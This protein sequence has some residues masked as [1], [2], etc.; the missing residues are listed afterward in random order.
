MNKRIFWVKSFLSFKKFLLLFLAS[1]ILIIIN[2]ASTNSKAFL[3]NYK[4]KVNII[5]EFY[6]KYSRIFFGARGYEINSYSNNITYS[7]KPNKLLLCT[8][9]KNENLYA[10]E[11]IEYYYHLGFNKIIIFDNNEI[12]GEKFDDILKDYI[13]K[14]IVDIEDIRGLKSIQMAAINYCYRKNMYLYDWIAFFDFDEY[15]FLNNYSNIKHYL[16]NKEFEKCQ[17]I[18]FNWYIYDDNNLLKYDNRRIVERFTH[19]KKI[20]SLTKFIARG[21]L[22]KLLISSAHIAININYCNSKGELV[23]PKS[24]LEL[25]KE[26][27][28]KAYIKHYY[29]KTA[30]EYCFKV[31]RG[32]VQFKYIN[33]NKNQII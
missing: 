18:L 10:K 19:L 9:G 23:Y 29:T 16:F 30:E 11:F 7:K 22:N 3:F 32:D 20:T 28:S 25:P 8:I 2:I 15:L 27:N 33:P 5:N 17:S 6:A 24:Y 21:N 26:N 13:S 31:R 14:K 12:F 1:Q 4:Q